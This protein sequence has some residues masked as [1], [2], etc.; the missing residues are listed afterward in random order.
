VPPADVP[1]PQSHHKRSRTFPLTRGDFVSLQAQIEY[2]CKTVE[3]V[4]ANIGSAFENK[5]HVSTSGLAVPEEGD[6]HQRNF[7]ILIDIIDKDH[8]IA[9]AII[10]S[11][12]SLVNNLGLFESGPEVLVHIVVKSDRGRQ[13]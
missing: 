6:S 11:T 9:S 1:P 8:E 10:G 2:I 7:F 4:A 3:A 5:A 12:R 13:N